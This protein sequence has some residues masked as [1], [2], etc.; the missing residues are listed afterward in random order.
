MEVIVI[1]F[2]YVVPIIIPSDPA[3]RAEVAED[4]CTFGEWML[5]G[6]ILFCIFSGVEVTIKGII[7]L[8]RYIKRK[9]KE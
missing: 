3:I 4:L 5:L 6:I 7:R 9:R 8:I 1:N 2:L